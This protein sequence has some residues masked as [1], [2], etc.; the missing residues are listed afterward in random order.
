MTSWA[1]SLVPVGS[2]LGSVLTMVG[3][4]RSDRLISRRERDGRLDEFRIPGMRLSRILCSPY[5]MRYLS[6]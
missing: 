2:A 4:A 5:R 6:M 3:Q 1:A